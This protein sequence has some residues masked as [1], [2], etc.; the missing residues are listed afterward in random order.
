VVVWQSGS[1]AGGEGED[2]SSLASGAPQRAGSPSPIESIVMAI[3]QSNDSS[4]RQRA[5]IAL[6]RLGAKAAAPAAV[7]VLISLLQTASDGE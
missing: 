3:Q 6:G 7:K 2:G 1:E 4:M 5:L